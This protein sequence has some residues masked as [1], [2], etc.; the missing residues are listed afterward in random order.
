[1]RKAET[2]LTE[3]LAVESTAAFRESLSAEEV[4]NR[5]Q[6][7]KR[8]TP[9]PKMTAYD[10]LLEFN[11]HLPGRDLVKID[12][13]ELDI[14]KDTIQIKATAFPTAKG[15]ALDGIQALETALKKSKCFKEITPGASES[16]KD[17][18]REFALAIKSSCT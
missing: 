4:N 18:S 13:R 16:G 2:V 5:I 8:K 1:L 9:I 17:D 7:G 14:K 6:P 12:I 10:T 15:S 3:R 11:A